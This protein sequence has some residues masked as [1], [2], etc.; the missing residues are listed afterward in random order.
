MAEPTILKIR[1]DRDRVNYFPFDVI[2]IV[3]TDQR[4]VLPRLFPWSL[5]IPIST[6]VYLAMCNMSLHVVERRPHDGPKEIDEDWK[7]RATKTFRTSPFEHDFINKFMVVPILPLMTT[8]VAKTEHYKLPGYL[9]AK[10]HRKVK[11]NK[12]GE[13]IPRRFDA[14]L[15]D[16]VVLFTPDG[17]VRPVCLKCRHHLLHMQGKCTLGDLA[18]YDELILKRNPYEQLQTND[19]DGP[20]DTDTS[21]G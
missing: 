19:A 16:G 17:P 2:Y 6:D 11:K 10:P 1:I 12:K 3:P 4:A 8:E 9:L 14:F 15:H 21:V 7:N 5:C 20:A 18:C 13:V